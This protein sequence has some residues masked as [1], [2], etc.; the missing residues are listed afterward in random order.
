MKLRTEAGSGVCSTRQ[1]PPVGG[2]KQAVGAPYT[3]ISVPFLRGDFQLI[4][5]VLRAPSRPTSVSVNL[6]PFGG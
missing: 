4:V 5:V 6:T 1:G 3:R 2:A